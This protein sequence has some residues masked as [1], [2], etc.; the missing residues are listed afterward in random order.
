MAPIGS[1]P[2]GGGPVGFANSFTGPATSLEVLGNFAYC[3]TGVVAVADTELSVVDTHTGNYYMMASIQAY[4]SMVA[5]ERYLLKVKLNGA[6][7]LETV[8]HLGVPDPQYSD[9]SPF[10]ILIPAYTQVEVTLENQEESNPNNWT[11]SV[12]GEIFRG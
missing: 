6:T 4:S 11:V 9:Q 5:N 2:G 3:Y 10:L 8:T 7:V 1:G 12:T